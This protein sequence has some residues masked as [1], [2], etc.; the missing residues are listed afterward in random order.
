MEGREKFF[1][2]GWV[3]THD[4]QNSSMLLY[5]LNYIILQGQRQLLMGN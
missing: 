2:P 5:Q 3:Q 1:D 4:H